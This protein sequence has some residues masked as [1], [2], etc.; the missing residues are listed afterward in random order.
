MFFGFGLIFKGQRPPAAGP[1]EATRLG[2]YEA[3]GLSDFLPRLRKRVRERLE[4]ESSGA[5]ELGQNGSLEASGGRPGGSLE[6]GGP[7]APK[8]IFE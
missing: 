3:T 2:V 6:L 7:E 4:N 5:S 8:Q 1:P